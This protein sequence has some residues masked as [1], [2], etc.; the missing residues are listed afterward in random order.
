MSNP[1]PPKGISKSR[2]RLNNQQ[3][4]DSGISIFHEPVERLFVFNVTR[5][6]KCAV[7]EAMTNMAICFIPLDHD[8]EPGIVRQHYIHIFKYTNE[9]FGNIAIISVAG[10]KH[11]CVF[12]HSE[13]H[14][15]GVAKGTTGEAWYAFSWHHLSEFQC[16][17]THKQVS[18]LLWYTLN[19]NAQNL[20]KYAMNCVHFVNVKVRN[21]CCSLF[22]VDW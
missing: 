6:L 3:D 7:A 22:H 9:R 13:T 16:Q 19:Q 15:S 2:Y 10:T 5:W 8:P 17:R 1:Q 12:I 20:L 14:A 18:L 11:G 4:S 21:W